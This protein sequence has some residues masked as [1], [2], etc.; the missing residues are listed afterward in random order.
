M[1]DPLTQIVTLLRPRAPFA[2]LAS[3][4]GAWRVRRDDLSGVFYNLTL[5]GRAVM[6]VG[7]ERIVLEAGDFVLAPD[8]KGFVMES[9]PA[10]PA[11]RFSTPR[12]VSPGQA[13]IG[14]EALPVTVQQLIGHC[15]FGARDAGLLV[16]LLPGLVV[17]RGSERLGMLTR[18]VAEEARAE[19]P[20]REVVLERLLEVLLIEAM[21]SDTG[22]AAAPGLLRG[23]AD[24]R[25]STVLRALHDDP[26]RAWTVAELARRAGLSR[27]TFFTRFEAQV[28]RPPMEYLTGWRM[29]LAKDWLAA[30]QLRSAEIAGRLG[31]GSAAAFATAFAREVG[32]PPAQYARSIA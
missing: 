15:S 17:V 5:M 22:P 24:A 25:L 32:L 14:D 29:T 10:P 19:R 9:D 26:G 28:G 3:A 13:R 6:V 2:K 18:L 31:Y 8:A 30:G 1:S 4:A 21:R 7:G 12:M 20:G 23:L 11:G 27:S 16:G